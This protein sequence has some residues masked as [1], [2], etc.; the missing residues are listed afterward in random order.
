[1][2]KYI[3]KRLL[4]MIPILLGISFL[5][6]LLI[7]ITPGDP[8]R[9]IL[10]TQATPQQVAE[11]RD[12]MGLNDPMMVRYFRFIGGVL[13]GDFGNSF[14]NSRS[15]WTE[16]MQRF[17]YTLL[18]SGLS[19]ILSVLIGVPLG[20]Y[21]ATHQYTWKDNA[22]IVA[23]LFCVSMPSFWFALI[24]VQVFCVK[25]GWLP[26]SGIE[27]WQGWILPTIS[28]ALGYAAG[29]S[30]QMRSSMLE[31]IRQDYIT[32]ARA[33]GQT[34]NKVLYRHA[35]KNALIPII[36]TVGSIFGMSL[37]GALIAEVIFSV[38]GLGSY[39]LSGLTQ[40]DYPVIQGSVLFLSALF[41]VVIL[42]IDIMFAFIDPRIRSQY[43]VRKKKYEMKI[44]GKEEVLSS[45]KA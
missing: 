40:R 44:E 12:K 4:M 27:K 18:I 30:R 7:D 42:L 29:I 39:T 45:G 17:P 35:L 19:L 34:E 25:L 41:S 5:V 2:A 6:I 31:V 24:L 32:T 37:G 15:V 26:P 3:I 10:G 38:P 21:A 14:S 36:M 22:A 20:V 8:A 16:M 11:L 43:V 28:L 33:K 23:S 13:K 9:L 1:M